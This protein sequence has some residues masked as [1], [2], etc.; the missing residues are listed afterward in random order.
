MSKS[1]KSKSSSKKE[2]SKESKIHK[3]NPLAKLTVQS[4][5]PTTS[6]KF[7]PL[8]AKSVATALKGKVKEK[9]RLI[10]QLLRGEKVRSNLLKES[11]ISGIEKLKA[12][13]LE[14]LESL[15]L[16]ELASIKVPREFKQEFADLFVNAWRRKIQN[17]FPQS[18][19]FNDTEFSEDSF[20]ALSKSLC[21]NVSLKALSFENCHLEELHI[22]QLA[23]FIR[24]HPAITSIH[25]DHNPFGSKGL[26][27]IAKAL[28]ENTTLVHISLINCNIGSK[29]IAVLADYLVYN[30][31]L[32]SINLSENSIKEEALQPLKDA[33]KYSSCEIILDERS[34]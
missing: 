3:I 19:R 13:L 20:E 5:H 10:R 34:L 30:R 6:H 2:S 8:G 25:L 29:G 18:L 24:V 15:P 26:A 33:K 16:S 32:K 27:I 9:I 22:R 12:D 11:S 4:S 21:L 31:S 14:E 7:Q 28:K 1:E 23:K 17:E